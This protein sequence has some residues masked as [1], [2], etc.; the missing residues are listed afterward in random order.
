[1]NKKSV[2]DGPDKEWE[3]ISVPRNCVLLARLHWGECEHASRPPTW[4]ESDPGNC[5]VAFGWYREWVKTASERDVRVNEK[6]GCPCMLDDLGRARPRATIKPQKGWGSNEARA[7]HLIHHG[8]S[9][10]L[11][12]FLFF[13]F[14]IF[15]VSFYL[16]CCIKLGYNRLF[17]VSA[18]P[19]RAAFGTLGSLPT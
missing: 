16:S 19:T 2:N 15:Y 4:T 5:A 3:I 18:L 9:P 1:M 10:C 17:G 12:M 13:Y 11:F 7:P 8:L 6:P 14:S